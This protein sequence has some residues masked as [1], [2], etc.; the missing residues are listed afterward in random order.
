LAG[1]KRD[2]DCG[3]G[4]KKQQDSLRLP[5]EFGLVGTR[6]VLGPASRVGRRRNR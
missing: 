3:D 1:L 4:D 6:I 5:V 2:P